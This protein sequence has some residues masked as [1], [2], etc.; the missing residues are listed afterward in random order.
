MQMIFIQFCHSKNLWC[1]WLYVLNERT[2]Y[3]L[4]ESETWKK[5]FTDETGNSILSK[6]VEL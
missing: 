3:Y 4:A 6:K 1:I 5:R 2:I